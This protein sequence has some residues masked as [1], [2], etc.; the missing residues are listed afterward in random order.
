MAQFLAADCRWSGRLPRNIDADT[1]DLSNGD[2]SGPLILFDSKRGTWWSSMQTLRLTSAGELTCP[3]DLFEAPALT[4]LLIGGNGFD[5]CDWGANVT[6][7][8][9]VLQ[10]DISDNNWLPFELTISPHVQYLRAARAN[11]LGIL[12]N[13]AATS[14]LYLDQ[15]TLDGNLL[16][17]SNSAGMTPYEQFVSLIG[18]NGAAP[19]LRLFSC[20][21]C[22]L[23]FAIDSLMPLLAH[24]D[25]L[26]VVLLADNALW[27]IFPSASGLDT[28]LYTFPL[29]ITQFSVAGNPGISGRLPS[30]DAVFQGLQMLDFSGTGIKG[31]VP[32]S[33]ANF[34][35]LTQLNVANTSVQCHLVITPDEKLQCDVQSVTVLAP[36][37]TTATEFGSLADPNAGVH[38]SALT[39]TGTGSTAVLAGPSLHG[40]TLCTCDS[41][42]FGLH[43]RCYR[44]PEGC[45]CSQDS[46][47]NCFP[48][49]QLGSI[50]VTTEIGIDGDLPV[51][52]GSIVP[53]T[54]AAVLP[55]P[56]TVTGCSV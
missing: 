8:T 34:P 22:G 55:C 15:L 42:S 49:V 7:P 5:G 29:R 52:D 1:L 36:S 44:C 21:S 9:D 17:P 30:A 23:S 45:T 18:T 32:S 3:I 40:Y 48:V 28:V 19:V 51:I 2:F 16:A 53:F 43:A 54:V 11:V 10:L 27:G 6:L 47:Q 39:I 33:W 13:T 14:P 38:C 37:Q 41:G 26:E 31:A 12:V 25:L 24:T 50:G 46:I 20:Q 56:R 35:A 4:T